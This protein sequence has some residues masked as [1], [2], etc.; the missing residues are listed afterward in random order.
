MYNILKKIKKAREME[1]QSNELAGQNL[2][3]SSI[4]KTIPVNTIVVDNER[5]GRKQEDLTY[6][7]PRFDRRLRPLLHCRGLF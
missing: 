7:Y 3:S 4:L 5:V 1:E 6:L 2:E